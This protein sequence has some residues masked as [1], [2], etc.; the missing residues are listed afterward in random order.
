LI[1]V[2]RYEP[3]FNRGLQVWTLSE[4]ERYRIREKPAFNWSQVMQGLLQSLQNKVC[5]G[6]AQDPSTDNAV[7][8]CEDKKSDTGEAAPRRRILNR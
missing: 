2:K 4:R 7:G 6:Q 5:F 8:E 3:A 1:S